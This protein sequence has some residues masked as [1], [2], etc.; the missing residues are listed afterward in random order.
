M[1][2]KY[3]QGHN[4]KDLLPPTRVQ[5]LQFSPCPN[6]PLRLWM[7]YWVIDEVRDFRTKHFPKAPSLNIAT[8]GMKPLTHNP[9]RDIQVPNNNTPYQQTEDN[10]YVNIKRF[11]NEHLTKFISQIHNLKEIMTRNW[12]KPLKFLNLIKKNYKNITSYFMMRKSKFF[13]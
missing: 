6:S 3:S 9:L 2:Q 1:D 13:H 4:S 10:T 5:L 11:K 7:D 12:E 8:L